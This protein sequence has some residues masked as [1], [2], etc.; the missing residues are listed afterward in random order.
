[1]Q[2]E[3]NSIANALELAMESPQSCAESS[4]CFFLSKMWMTLKYLDMYVVHALISFCVCEYIS[5]TLYVLICFEETSSVYLP[6]LDIGRAQLVVIFPC[7]KQGP[8]YPISFDS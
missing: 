5:L 1:M 8:V 6:F 7:G 4:I 3:R 2:K